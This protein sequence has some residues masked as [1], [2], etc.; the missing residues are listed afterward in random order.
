MKWSVL[1]ELE[2]KCT[3]LLAIAFL[4][5]LLVRRFSSAQRHLILVLAMVGGLLIPAAHFLLPH[6]ETMFIPSFPEE[7]AEGITAAEEEETLPVEAVAPALP[8][9]MDV[10]RVLRPKVIAVNS[11]ETATKESRE[12]ETPVSW[13]QLGGGVWLSGFVCVVLFLVV[14]YFS[15][16]REVRRASRIQGAWLLSWD[17]ICGRILLRH[18]VSVLESDSR[19]APMA[20][21]FFGASIVLPVEG[22][23]W[24]EEK[25]VA[26][27]LHELAHVKRKDCLVHLLGSVVLAVHWFNPL[28]WMAARSLRLE[29]E[30]ACD[31][32][33]LTNGAVAEEYADQLLEVARMQSC[34]TPLLGAAITM[35]RKNALE[36][37]LLAI[38][39]RHR[40]RSALG[41]GAICLTLLL[42]V[43]VALPLASATGEKVPS[44]VAE[45]EPVETE[46]SAVVEDDSIVA[47]ESDPLAESESVLSIE[48]VDVES[49]DSEVTL[50]PIAEAIPVV[51]EVA[52]VVFEVETNRIEVVDGAPDA[53]AFLDEWIELGVENSAALHLLV[54]ENG[55]ALLFGAGVR[56]RMQWALNYDELVL[57]TGDGS[58]TAD[59]SADD[60]LIYRKG[61]REKMRF[62][63][64]S[65]ADHWVGVAVE[66]DYEGPLQLRLTAA[67]K[68]SS[69]LTTDRVLQGIALDAARLGCLD[70]LMQAIH[71]ISSRE[72]SDSTAEQCVS[73]FLEQGLVSEAL[74]LTDCISS[75]T[76]CDRML[77]KIAQWKAEEEPPVVSESRSPSDYRATEK[78][79]ERAMEQVDDVLKLIEGF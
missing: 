42:M 1:C 17:Q 43:A 13:T 9:D 4:A 44:V 54:E 40:R 53:S 39:D 22:R 15:A 66:E 10:E 28:F 6:W 11:M 2:L 69:R 79:V 61:G 31:D 12:K 58:R 71:G 30:H 60:L 75:T 76:L 29:R 74:A 50:E 49:L 47:E 38:L 56:K 18:G 48:A 55:Q 72:M 62:C 32:Y 35:A 59:I 63:R 24:P 33:V 7:R 37:R 14:G 5:V 70:P 65:C 67:A 77:A 23:D 41:G 3:L 27:L 21:E 78:S 34:R 25:R 57:T 45:E 26:V 8:V 46:I 20:F 36:G 19:M 51:V 16:G 73:I 68:I 52:P 64:V